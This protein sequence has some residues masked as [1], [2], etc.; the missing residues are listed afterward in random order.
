M[1]SY[2]MKAT[3]IAGFLSSVFLWQTPARAAADVSGADKE[4]VKKAS[5]INVAEIQAGGVAQQ[6]GSSSQVKMLAEHMAKDHSKAE[7]ELQSLAKSKGIELKQDTTVGK[8]M[9]TMGLEKANGEKFDNEFLE[10]QAKDHQTAIK[11]FETELQKG[12]DP[13]IKSWAEKTIP[14]LKSHLAMAEGNQ[15]GKGSSSTRQHSSGGG[16]AAQATSD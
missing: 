5:E 4:F 11:L 13:E 8:K 1:K 12:S 6:K 9:E 10:H 15:A 16:G 7:D 14:V 2:L 3:A